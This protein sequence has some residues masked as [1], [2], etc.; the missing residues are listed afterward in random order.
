M[1][2]IASLKKGIKDL[3]TSVAEATEQRKNEN[4]DFKD[5]M[6]SNSAAKELLGFAKNRLIKLYKPP[7]KA[8][9]SG[10]ERIA[11][12]MGSEAAPTTTPSGIA[13]TGIAGQK[14]DGP[15]G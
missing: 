1:G 9:L 6:A 8:E 15:R 12:N 4:V 7:A 10:E 14:L 2:E 5:L 3:D 11:V 13:G